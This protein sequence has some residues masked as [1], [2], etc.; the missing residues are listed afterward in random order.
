MAL[1]ANVVA[2]AQAAGLKIATAESCTG[3]L[4]AAAL[5]ETP[6]ASKVFDRGFITYSYASK[7]ELL[8]V[9]PA[10]VAA[11]GAVSAEVAAQMASG[12]LARSEADIA[13]AVTGIAGPVEGGSKPEGRVWFAISTDSSVE[14]TL[15][16][17]GALGRANVRKASVEQALALLLGAIKR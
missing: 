10:S 5:T 7:P 13:I 2:A 11:H 16:D 3:G 17:F 8:A 4:L 9:D 6:G 14:T 12:A 15:R 1:A